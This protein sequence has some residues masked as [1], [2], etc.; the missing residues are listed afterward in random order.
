MT[1]SREAH[2][3]R[4]AAAREESKKVWSLMETQKQLIFLPAVL[5]LSR[6]APL[7]YSIMVGNNVICLAWKFFVGAREMLLNC[8]C[9]EDSLLSLLCCSSDSSGCLGLGSTASQNLRQ[10]LLC[11]LSVVVCQFFYSLRTHNTK[12]LSIKVRS[13]KVMKKALVSAMDRCESTTMMMRWNDEV[14]W[15]IR[16]KKADEEREYF[17]RK[18]KQTTRGSLIISMNK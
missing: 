6:K 17:H 9:S 16:R 12:K 13:N 15:T 1:L 3:T 2:K 11:Q 4:T 18:A 8:E 5:L 7:A 14:A 10:V